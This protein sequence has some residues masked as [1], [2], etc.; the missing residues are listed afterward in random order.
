MS[1]VLKTLFYI[2]H[3]LKCSNILFYKP[4]NM[5]A[6]TRLSLNFPCPARGLGGLLGYG[7]PKGVPA[8]AGG[9]RT[10]QSGKVV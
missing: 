3:S 6:A 1:T 7:T 4:M 8:S 5:T 10:R 9:P 2:S